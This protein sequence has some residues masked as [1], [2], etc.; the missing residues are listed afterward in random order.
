MEKV[1]RCL[2]IYQLAPEFLDWN[3]QKRSDNKSNSTVQCRVRPG[4]SIAGL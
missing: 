2:G 3:Y 1:S 4:L